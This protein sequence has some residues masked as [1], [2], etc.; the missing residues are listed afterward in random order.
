MEDH[1]LRQLLGELPLE[2]A[3]E[4]FTARVMVR[5]DA[6]PEP[7]VWRQPRL[8]FAAAVLA[9]TVASA[10]FLQ[11]RADRQTEH[12]AAE[13]RQLLQE[14]R[15]EHESLKQELRELSEPSV[16]YLG[17]DEKVDLVVDLSGTR[18]ATF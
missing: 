16:V 12:R 7:R 15:S 2:R 6:T 1:N 11:I 17:G 10:G 18:N 14:L 3:S 5:L 13:A 9:A 8:V 4:G